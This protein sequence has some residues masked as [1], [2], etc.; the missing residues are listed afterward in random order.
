MESTKNT[1]NGIHQIKKEMKNVNM[2]RLLK[3]NVNSDYQQFH[4][5]QPP[6]IDNWI[7]NTEPAII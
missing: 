3:E 1:K 5:Y 6:L 4:L 7:S 2:L